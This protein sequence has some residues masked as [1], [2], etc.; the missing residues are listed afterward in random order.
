MYIYTGRLCIVMTTLKLSVFSI[1]GVQNRDNLHNLPKNKI[2]YYR[3]AIGI[4]RMIRCFI[5]RTVRC[6][7]KMLSFCI[8]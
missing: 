6:L 8:K 5:L 2:A 3:E 4:L 1:Q 7:D